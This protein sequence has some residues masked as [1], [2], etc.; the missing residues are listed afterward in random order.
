MG[1]S[2]FAEEGVKM[3]AVSEQF[4]KALFRRFPQWRQYATYREDGEPD[5][6]A[7]YLDVAI[8]SENPAVAD[9]LRINR[10][11]NLITVCWASAIVEW[12]RP[13]PEYYT[14]RIVLFLEDVVAEKIVFGSYIKDYN[15]SSG[16][17]WHRA[18][19]DENAKGFP[20]CRPK[21][22]TGGMIVERSWRGSYDETIREGEE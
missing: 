7:Y 12:Y 10:Y 5:D 21:M 9:P 19:L 15:V 22:Q 20:V 14:E 2:V 3:E 17:F 4:G 16:G 1:K 6:R 18:P 13:P 8:P 11:P